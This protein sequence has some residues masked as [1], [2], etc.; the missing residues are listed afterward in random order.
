MDRTTQNTD[1]ST[2][3]DSSIDHSRSTL[4]APLACSDPTRIGSTCNAMN[5]ACAM[6]QP[7]QNDGLCDNDNRTTFG[8]SCSCT[9]DFKGDQCQIDRQICRS[10]T[11]LHNGSVHVALCLHASETLDA[12]FPGACV[13][14]SDQAFLCR[15]TAGW[16]GQ[17]C[18]T[19]VDRCRNHT[20]QNHGVCQS[21]PLGYVCHCLDGS[22]SGSQCELVAKRIAILHRISQSLGYIAIVSIIAVATCVIVLDVLKYGFGIDP[23]ESVSKKPSLR[24]GKKK[25]TKPIGRVVPKPKAVPPVRYINRTDVESV[26]AMTM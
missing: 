16:Q 13:T 20:C 15:C 21:L 23:V 7:C 9:L 22:F 19:R 1:Y 11:C 12:H 10:N 14:E 4:F 2:T 26:E 25:S 8:Y 24:Q 6:M 5:T 17:H 3:S 18:E